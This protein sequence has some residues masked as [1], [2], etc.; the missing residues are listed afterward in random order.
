[1][2]KN[3]IKRSWANIKVGKNNVHSI[4]ELKLWLR[5]WSVFRFTVVWYIQKAF[6]SILSTVEIC[7]QNPVCFPYNWK[8][9]PYLL[10]HD[11]SLIIIMIYF[12]T[13]RRQPNLQRQL[14]ELVTS[15]FWEGW[16]IQFEL[17]LIAYLSLDT[18]VI[19]TTIP[20]TLMASFTLFPAVFK[21]YEKH[22]K[23]CYSKEVL[24]RQF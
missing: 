22:Y 12:P 8:S 17:F 10:C 14:D 21:T 16:C 20:C 19:R 9:L 23:C 24:Q 13:G 2:S 5:L 18:Y 15:W 3:I 7:L 11:K 4:E 6:L 1:M